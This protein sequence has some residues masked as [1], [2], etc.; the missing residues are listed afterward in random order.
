MLSIRIIA[1]GLGTAA[2]ALAAG[3]FMQSKQSRTAAVNAPS[4]QGATLASGDD[5]LELSDIK[6]TSALPAAPTSALKAATLPATPVSLSLLDDTPIAD[7]P[8]E[9]PA[10]SFSCDYTLTAEPAAAAMVTL[11]LSVPC[12]MNERFTVHHNGMMFTE[13]TDMDGAA[14]MI[15]PALSAK[16]VFIVSFVNGEGAVASADL[17]SF[18]Y[19]DRVV[20]QWSGYSGLQ[21][22]AM[23]YDADYGDAGHVWAEAA[24]DMA[25]AASGTGGFITRLGAEDA[26]DAHRAE[27]YTFPSGLAPKGGQVTLSVEAEV[28][29]QN[30]GRDVEAQSLQVGADMPLTV[31]DLTL[32]MPE[33]NAVGDFLV[34]RN[35]LNDLKIAQK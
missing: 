12:M 13:V 2:I 22:H 6:L 30:C 11:N 8:G 21:I 19:Y 5:Q 14:E 17:S 26:A 18:E 16:P 10:Q 33:C 28:T 20:V 31:R 23:E 35:L 4:V 34:M 9:E 25:D 24:H 1:A 32:A 7:L 27:I 3:H 15:V 29:E